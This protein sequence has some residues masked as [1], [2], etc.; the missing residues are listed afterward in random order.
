MQNILHAPF[1][2][3]VP[4]F[5]IFLPIKHITKTQPKSYK[6]LTMT[7]LTSSRFEGKNAI[8]KT[9]KCGTPPT[10]NYKSFNVT[11]P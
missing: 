7:I 5:P 9:L 10:L 8:K 11:I 1:I 4:S 2:L 6:H 3:I